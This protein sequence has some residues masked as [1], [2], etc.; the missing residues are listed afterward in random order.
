MA[1]AERS[2]ALDPGSAAGHS[3]LANATLL[4]ENDRARAGEEF[5]RAL[6]LNPSYALGRCWYALFYLQWA[7]GEIEQG[8]TEAR[9][10]LDLDPMN[11]YLAM[12]LGCCYCTAGRLEEAVEVGRRAIQ[13][14]PES[15]VAHWALGVSL[16][17]A[18]QLAGAVAILEKAA[19]MS[20]RHARALCSLA[21]V[22]GAWGKPSDAAWL[23]RE[24]SERSTRSFVPATYLALAAEGAGLREEALA[25]AQR[26]GKDREPT[27]LLHARYFPEFQALRSNPRFAAILREMDAR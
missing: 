23:F 20:S 18:G 26:A 2:I 24:L 25:L 7:R 22:F 16:R 13:L 17:M 3:A 12:I 14:D 15:F 19:A 1:A 10:A 9:R 27:F 21:G 4:Y 11:S 6:E 8:V 5:E